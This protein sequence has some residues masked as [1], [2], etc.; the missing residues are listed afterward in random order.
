MSSL[1]L[2]DNSYNL[3]QVGSTRISQTVPA[4]RSSTLVALS[5]VVGA[6]SAGAVT[7][8]S[9]FGSI[10]SPIIVAAGG[11]VGAAKK[12]QRNSPTT[13][14]PHVPSRSDKDVV[15][16]VKEHSGL[17]WE[18]LAKAFGVSRRAVHLW[19][20]GGHMNA[21]NAEVLRDLEATIRATGEQDPARVRAALTTKQS[22]GFSPLE[23]L[24]LQATSDADQISR[25]P[26]RPI[27]LL[28]SSHVSE[29]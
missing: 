21:Q 26:H 1:L 13:V 10:Q 9:A 19:A 14:L 12:P 4:W 15:T 11:G 27:E 17:T 3:L 16:W 18:Q 2:P 28:D 22:N 20:S 8:V 7:Q 24:R 29:A 23:Q 6:T 25:T 5:L